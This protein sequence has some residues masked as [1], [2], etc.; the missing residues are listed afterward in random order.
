MNIKTKINKILKQINK[1]PVATGIMIITISGFYT[2]FIGLI[3]LI[4]IAYTNSTD[5]AFLTL[6]SVVYNRGLLEILIFYLAYKEWC[7]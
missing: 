1:H 5:S 4:I 2:F 7:K 6:S 3:A